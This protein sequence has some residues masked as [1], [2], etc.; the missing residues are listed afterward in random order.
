MMY[1]NLGK[2]FEVATAPIITW[3]ATQAE[4]RYTT[5]NT[6]RILNCQEEDCGITDCID[7]QGCTGTISINDTNRTTG[8]SYVNTEP[9][10]IPHVLP[11]GIVSLIKHVIYTLKKE[12]D[13]KSYKLTTVVFWE[14]DVKTIVSN[15][16]KDSIDTVEV[17]GVITAT[18]AAK[19]I[20]LAYSIIKF[21]MG[22]DNGTGV[23]EGNGYINKLDKVIRN[24]SYDSQLGPVKAAQEK[25]AA[26]KKHLEKVEADQARKKKRDEGRLNAIRELLREELDTLK[27]ARS[28]E[29]K[30]KH[31]KPAAKKTAKK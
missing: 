8:T 16:L 14:N 3:S 5:S 12:N 6:L 2:L 26:Y 31:G 30:K 4:P 18:P 9:F 24:K 10:E 13:T 19:E 21:L 7:C 20:G 25:E 15:S 28:E 23:I 22:K 11:D 27:S 29:P 1:S 17:D